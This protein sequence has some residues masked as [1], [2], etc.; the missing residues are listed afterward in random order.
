MKLVGKAGEARQD[1]QR[2]GSAE[3]AALEDDQ[4]FVSWHLRDHEA[5]SPTSWTQDK[6]CREKVR[7]LVVDQRNCRALRR[8]AEISPKTGWKDRSKSGC[9]LHFNWLKTSDEDMVTLDP[10]AIDVTVS[11]LLDEKQAP[12]KKQEQDK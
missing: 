2:E 11:W 12:E 4:T 10:D 5:L 8:Q 1:L 6:S 3:F 9:R 7:P